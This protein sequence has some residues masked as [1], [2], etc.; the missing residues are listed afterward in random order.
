MDVKTE[1]E[2]AV[3]TPEAKRQVVVGEE[4]FVVG[5]PVGQAH[6]GTAHPLG[7]GSCSVCQGEAA[8]DSAHA[9]RQRV[10]GTCSVP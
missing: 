3:D 1:E 4:A 5:S 10:R 9:R 2:K 7:V 6:G 8:G